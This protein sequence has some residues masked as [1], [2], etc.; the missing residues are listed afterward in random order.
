[1]L[2]TL[3]MTKLGHVHDGLMVSMEIKNE[4]LAERAIVIVQKITG[5]SRGRASSSLEEANNNIKLAVLLAIG[6]SKP[7]AKKALENSKGHLRQALKLL[8]SN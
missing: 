4:K 2:S 3:V 5:E 6:C 8:N 1:M 7:E